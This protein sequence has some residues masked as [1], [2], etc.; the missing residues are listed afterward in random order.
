[1]TTTKVKKAEANKKNAAVL[2][3]T[4][5]SIESRAKAFELQ[6]MNK[7]MLLRGLFAASDFPQF[8]AARWCAGG[9]GSAERDQEAVRQA[10]E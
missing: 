4:Q 3:E 1:M 9:Q 6:I 10:R 5:A 7:V 8:S 2:A